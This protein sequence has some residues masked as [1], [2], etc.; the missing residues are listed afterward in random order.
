MAISRQRLSRIQ[1]DLCSVLLPDNFFLK[2]KVYSGYII[3]FSMKSF[4]VIIMPSFS[5]S[6]PLHLDYADWILYGCISSWNKNS[7]YIKIKVIL[8]SFRNCLF[9]WDSGKSK[10]TVLKLCIWSIF[11]LVA[12]LHSYCL[13]SKHNVTTKHSHL[14]TWNPLS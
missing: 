13:C 6:V 3:N 4:V 2:W 9:C 12:E 8:F 5:I 11:C 7:F 1:K 10:C 14:I